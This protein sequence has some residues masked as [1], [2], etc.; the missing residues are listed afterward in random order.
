MIEEKNFETTLNNTEKIVKAIRYDFYKFFTVNG[1]RR[2]YVKRSKIFQLNDYADEGYVVESGR[3]KTYKLASDGKEIIFNIVNPGEILGLAEVLLNCPR[4][5]YAET[6]CDT[7]VWIMSKKQLFDL[8]YSNNDLCFKFLWIS[9]HQVLR[10]QN[11]VEDLAVLPVKDRVIKLLVRLCKELG[12]Q[13]EN[14]TIIDFPITH[15]E[16]AQMVGST[17]QT[18]TLI[19]NELRKKGILDWKQKK[20]KILR[21]MD[22]IDQT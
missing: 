2:S 1:Y 16:I 19:L 18:V 9:T 10:Y 20:I 5:R 15:E 21:W 4:M 7:T 14:Y 22:L 17:R 12:I 8:F 3:V 13:K 6:L 11:I